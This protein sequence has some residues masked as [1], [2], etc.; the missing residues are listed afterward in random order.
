LDETQNQLIAVKTKNFSNMLKI[1]RNLNAKGEY[2]QLLQKSEDLLNK[3]VF[4]L[5]KIKFKR[6]HAVMI[7][8]E[9][10]KLT[11]YL[12][13]L[14]A[15]STLPKTNINYINSFNKYIEDIINPY[16]YTKMG[17]PQVSIIPPPSTSGV[18]SAKHKFIFS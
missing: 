11:N 7:S 17:K 9:I 1:L 8:T 10:E 4:N 15:Q 6:Y 13:R 16:Y 2:M 5:P 18:M 12:F 3:I 14:A